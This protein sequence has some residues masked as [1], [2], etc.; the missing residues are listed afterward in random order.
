[1]HFGLEAHPTPHKEPQILHHH[2][3][4]ENPSNIPIEEQILAGMIIPVFDDR[5]PAE[6]LYPRVT[7][8]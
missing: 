4:S 5:Q 2:E 3:L 1:L 7:N 6:I 8:L